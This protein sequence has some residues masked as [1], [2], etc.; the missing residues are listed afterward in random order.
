MKKRISKDTKRAI[1]AIRAM[2]E[3]HGETL[4]DVSR[5]ASLRGIHF[6]RIMQ[7][8]EILDELGELT[9]DGV[10]VTRILLG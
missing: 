10:N 2:G 4:G 3:I 5:A 6:G 7:A 1:E 8:A 9:Y